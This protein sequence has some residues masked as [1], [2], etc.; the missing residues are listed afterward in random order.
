MWHLG[1]ITP[2]WD[3]SY[4]S[5]VYT[6]QPIKH[7]EITEWRSQG[8]YNSSFSGEMY[9]HPNSMPEWTQ[10]VSNQIGLRD[11]GYVFY[12]MKTLDIMPIHVDHFETYCRVF[13]TSRNL[14]F[15]A[16]VFLEDWKSGHYFEI[17]SNA[18]TDWRAGEYVIW[19]SDE[20]HAASNIGILDR[21]T[22]QITGRYTHA[23]S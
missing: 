18:I 8:Y 4:K 20:P 13:S 3:D 1:H 2:C 15:R 22:L 17:G 7:S 16:I 19:D 14:V 21:Y 11:C 10:V 6:K 12:R 9:G 23:N 5:F